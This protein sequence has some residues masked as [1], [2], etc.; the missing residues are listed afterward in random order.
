M[1]KLQ[2][3]II[4]S[5]YFKFMLRTD[6]KGLG[7][8]AIHPSLPPN[9][10]PFAQVDTNIRR[11]TSIDEPCRFQACPNSKQSMNWPTKSI[12]D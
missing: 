1:F 9:F 6:S 10:L 7:A 3:Q 2:F 8:S 12:F 11:G 5:S 4:C